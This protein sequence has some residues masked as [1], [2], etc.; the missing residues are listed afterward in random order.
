[1]TCRPSFLQASMAHLG[2][3]CSSFSLLGVS[4]VIGLEER[5][6]DIRTLLSSCGK[7]PLGY[8]RH[9]AASLRPDP[10]HSSPSTS[11]AST[12]RGEP[13]HEKYLSL[14]CMLSLSAVCP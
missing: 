4:S 7:R 13:L 2:M 5:W 3:F 12:F 8:R 14:S 9:A 10:S 1:M 6:F 11:L